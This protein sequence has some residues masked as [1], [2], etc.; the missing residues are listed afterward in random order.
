MKLSVFYWL[1]M[2]LVGMKFYSVVQIQHLLLH[3]V[4][5]LFAY[6]RAGNYMFTCLFYFSSTLQ[7][8]LLAVKN[9]YFFLAVNLFHI[10]QIKYIMALRQLH[11]GLHFK[12][13]GVFC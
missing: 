13:L 10:Q 1:C 12:S 7:L 8:S 3:G 5:R 2:N 11:S 9:V 6:F 4:L